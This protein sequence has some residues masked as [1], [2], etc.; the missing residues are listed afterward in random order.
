MRAVV[1]E[2]F[3]EPDVL[4]VR[5]VPDPEPGPEEVLVEVVSSALVVAPAKPMT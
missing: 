3:G 1:I 4:V 5:E 2:S